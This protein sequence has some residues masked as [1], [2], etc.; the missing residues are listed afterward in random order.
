M[1]NK[2]FFKRK[3]VSKEE[4]VLEKAHNYNAHFKID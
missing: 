3:E 1:K 4:L 2:T